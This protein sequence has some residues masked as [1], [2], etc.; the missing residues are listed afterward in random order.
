MHKNSIIRSYLAQFEVQAR[1]N[2]KKSNP[3]KF[4]FQETKALKNFLRVL[5]TELCYI[6]GKG[7]AKKLLIFQEV[8]FCA[9]TI[10]SKQS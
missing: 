5:E 9:R 4:P 1:K 2:E 7:N 6:S 3:K 8:T 10:K